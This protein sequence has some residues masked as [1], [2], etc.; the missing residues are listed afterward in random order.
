[1]QPEIALAGVGRRTSRKLSE[2]RVVESDVDEALR[3]NGIDEGL[4]ATSRQREFVAQSGRSHAGKGQ[5]APQA[6][7][8]GLGDAEPA[9]GI[10][11]GELRTRIAG[12]NMALRALEAELY[13]ARSWDHDELASIVARLHALVLRAED[14]RLFREMVPEET[15][16]LIDVADSPQ[17]AITL[18]AARIADARQHISEGWDT[19]TETERLAELGRLNELSRRLAEIAEV[20]GQ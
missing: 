8:P 14:M 6:T 5:S 17:P 12:T 15:R 10:N 16:G 9:V 7:R 20:L 18:A 4:S 13:D 11:V 3:G 19:G 1:M 2:P